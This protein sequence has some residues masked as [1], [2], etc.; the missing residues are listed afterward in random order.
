METQVV[1]ATH[2]PRGARP[3]FSSGSRRGRIIM[4]AISLQDLT[5]GE[6]LDT[7]PTDPMAIFAYLLI[8]AFIWFI[9]KGSRSSGAPPSGPPASGDPPRTGDDAAPAGRR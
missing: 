2:A 7:I 5:F 1:T 6:V 4:L 8:A 9:W 3:R